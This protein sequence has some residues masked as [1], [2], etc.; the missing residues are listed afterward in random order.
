M[1]A[2]DF[3]QILDQLLLGKA[4]CILELPRELV[5]RYPSTVVDGSWDLDGSLNAEMEPH[6]CHAKHKAL[7]LRNQTVLRSPLV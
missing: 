4:V 3:V 5:V 6:D 1:L 2:D 7:V